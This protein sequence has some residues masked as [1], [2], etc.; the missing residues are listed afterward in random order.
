MTI[1]EQLRGL[2]RFSNLDKLLEATRLPI[3]YSPEPVIGI[4]PSIVLGSDGP[5][6]ARLLLVTKRFLCDIQLDEARSDFDYVETRSI[7]NYR[8]SL[9]THAVKDQEVVKASYDI[10]RVHLVH[11]G[12]I[13]RNFSTSV[14]Y[15]GDARDQWIKNVMKLIPI[16]TIAE[17]D[18]R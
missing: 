7:R 10:A 1:E 15:A 9:W 13:A 3:E 8:F 16:S 2:E 4:V 6:L 17:T 12:G 11:G 14:E 5:T 18:T